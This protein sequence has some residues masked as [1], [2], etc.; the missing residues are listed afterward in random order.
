MGTDQPVNS[1]ETAAPAGLTLPPGNDLLKAKVHV[2][3]TRLFK[4]YLYEFEA[5]IDEHDSAMVKL[6]DALPDE[7]K[8]YVNLADY[9]TDEK[10]ATTRNNVLR[11]GNETIRDLIEM[12]DFLDRMER[13]KM[14]AEPKPFSPINADLLQKIITERTQEILRQSMTH[15]GQA[16]TQPGQDN[17]TIT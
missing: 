11:V 1:Q 13:I 2:G 12:I 15:G 10:I 7:F 5:M 6:R 16:T 4:T 9:V 14:A 8:S 3:I 17:T